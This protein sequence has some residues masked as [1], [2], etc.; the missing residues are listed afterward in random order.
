MAVAALARPTPSAH[1]A[2]LPQAGIWRH[3]ADVGADPQPREAWRSV[4]D[5]ICLPYVETGREPSTP[6]GQVLSIS[7]RALAVAAPKR[8]AALPNVPTQTLSELLGLDYLPAAG[9]LPAALLRDPGAAGHR[10]HRADIGRA[11]C[12]GAG[13]QLPEQAHSPDRAGAA[14]GR[15]GR[16]G[17]AGCRASAK[18]M[19]TARYRGQQAG[20]QHHDGGLGSLAC[21]A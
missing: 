9:P 16:H 18:Q 11:A 19:G 17:A 6:R 10:R 3:V 13:C 5:R 14:R 12:P 15:C 21:P 4:M 8:V 20:C 7:A 2:A 1:P